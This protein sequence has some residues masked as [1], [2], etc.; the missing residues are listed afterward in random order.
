MTSKTVSDPEFVRPE[1]DKVQTKYLFYFFQSENAQQQFNSIIS[2]SAQPQLPIRDLRFVNLP[3]PDI[4]AQQQM[5][6]QIE[7]EKELVKA[8]KLLI[9]IFEQ[10]IKDRIAEVWGEK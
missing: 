8:N 7:R 3:L 2:G 4:E 6:A 1:T 10:K 9:E 5:V